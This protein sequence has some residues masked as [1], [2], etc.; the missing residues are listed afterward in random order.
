[1]SALG[2]VQ[3]HMAHGFTQAE[4]E[5]LETMVRSCE[6]SVEQAQATGDDELVQL[7]IERGQAIIDSVTAQIFIDRRVSALKAMGN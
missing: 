6:R 1:M 5:L 7:V 2:T 4:A 3:D